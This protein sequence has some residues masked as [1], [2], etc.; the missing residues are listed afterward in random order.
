MDDKVIIKDI[1]LNEVN[2]EN[3]ACFIRKAFSSLSKFGIKSPTA[4]VTEQHIR[5]KYTHLYYAYINNCVVGV[6]AGKVFGNK[7]R[8]YILAVSENHQNKGIGQL[9]LHYTIKEIEQLNVRYIYLNTML[10]AKSNIHLY[11]KVVLKNLHL[12]GI[13][14]TIFQLFLEDILKKRFLRIYI[15][16]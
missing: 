6:S 3:L 13:R 11:K 10:P 7:F 14:R 4:N 2:Y 5:N 1:N 16:I 12:Q 9:L 15:V 8:L